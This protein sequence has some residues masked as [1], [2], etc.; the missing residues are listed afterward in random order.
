MIVYLTKY[1]D[2]LTLSHDYFKMKI[3][4]LD[5]YD[6]FTYNLVHL[7]E[8]LSDAVFEVFR[9]DEIELADVERFDKILL[10]PGPG[11]PSEAG[12]MAELISM[13]VARKPILG[14]CLGLQGITEAFGGKLKNLEVPLHGM[15]TKVFITNK[16]E[17]IF[18][19]IPEEFTAGH[20]H[21][22][23]ADESVLPECLEITARDE[24][25]N[26]MG[27]RHKSYDVCGVQF[28]PESILTPFGKK[29]IKN[30]ITL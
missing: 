13:Y 12:I 1:F 29:I 20:Y 26:I 22:W 8:P 19:G 18:S 2:E 7:I 15:E 28:H 27:L 4:V 21:S 10:S 17:R 11:L 6:S 24:F 9:N 16:N 30:W 25:N 23:V 5:N 14:V 3:L